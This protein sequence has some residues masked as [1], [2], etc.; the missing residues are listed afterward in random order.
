MGEVKVMLL[1]QDDLMHPNTG[2]SNYNESAYYNF[3]DRNERIGGFLRLGNRPNEGYAEM[4]ICLY[5]PDGTVGFMFQ[6][7]EIKDNHAHDSGGMKFEVIKP[8]ERHHIGY[9]GKVCVL[10]NPL[11]MAEPA[12]AFKSNPYADAKLDLDYLAVSPGWGGELREKTA[13]GWVAPAPSGNPEA[14]FARGHL[15][16]L[17]HAAGK[18]VLNQAGAVREYRIDGLG[19][20]DHSWGPRYWQAPK[21]YRWL[22][23][24]FDEEL[25]GMATITV[26]RDGSERPGGF[27]ARKG[28]P[29]L[30]IV[31]VDI[32]T[33]FSGE[34][35]LHDKIKVECETEEGG[36]PIVITGRV[37][38]MIPLRNRRAGAVT[39]IAEGMTEWNWNGKIGFGLS[40]YLDH[41]AE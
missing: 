25:G 14:Q 26:N 36:A 24:N 29:N 38:S 19:L 8:F 9:A 2:E 22:T 16:Q 39:R 34:Q 6:R 17:G 11:E 30:N 23:M 1:D 32:Q 10:K 27:I 13:Q 28:K 7:P 41:L 20:R 5:L 33:E 35:R 31:K 21:Y 40:E 37:L 15:E 18:L 12:Q 3:F 4:T